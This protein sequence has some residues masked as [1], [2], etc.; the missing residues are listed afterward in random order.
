MFQ[1][2]SINMWL[3]GSTDWCFTKNEK[4]KEKKIND[5]EFKECETGKMNRKLQPGGRKKVTSYKQR[6]NASFKSCQW[7]SKSGWTPV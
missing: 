1:L 3:N 2:Q 5:E 7:P 4:N 6:L